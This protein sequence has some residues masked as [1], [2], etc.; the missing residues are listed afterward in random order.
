[1]IKTRYFKV[2]GEP[3]PKGRPRASL[4]NGVPVIYTP[5]STS[6]Y[7][8]YVRGCYQNQVFSEMIPAG[9]PLCMTVMCKLKIPESTT[10]KTKDM[11]LKGFI[12]PTKRP[13]IDNILKAVMDA[14]NGVAYHDDA[15]I[16]VSTIGKHYGDDP[17]LEVWISEAE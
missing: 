5:K 12:K 10:K 9:I 6:E 7:E 14:L 2:P 3:H 1:M 16:Q 11:M 13:D 8:E 17:C 4:R 15:Q